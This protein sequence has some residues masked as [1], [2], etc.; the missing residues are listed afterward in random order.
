[1]GYGAKPGAKALDPAAEGVGG[2]VGDLIGSPIGVG[3]GGAWQN[4]P[5]VPAGEPDGGQWT[6]GGG[7][8]LGSLSTIAS[9]LLGQAEIDRTTIA[10]IW[11]D[12]EALGGAKPRFQATPKGADQ[13]IFPNGGVIRFDLFP[14]Q[15]LKGQVPHIN[16]QGFPGQQDRLH[17]KLK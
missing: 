10:A 14:G 2:G 3:A 17:I 12:L 13:W 9:G 7:V 15:Y 4:Q 1:M 8:G 6:S 16:L 5:R 11:D